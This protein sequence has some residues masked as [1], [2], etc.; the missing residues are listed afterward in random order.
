MLQCAVLAALP[1]GCFGAIQDSSS[2]MLAFLLLPQMALKVR[3]KGLLTQLIVAP[4]VLAMPLPLQQ[5][6]VRL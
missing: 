2:N 4:A 3:G 1:P 6:R 5:Q